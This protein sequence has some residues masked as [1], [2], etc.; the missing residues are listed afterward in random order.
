MR[1]GLKIAR[2]AIA[3]RLVFLTFCLIH[4]PQLF[5]GVQQKVKEKFLCDLCDSS[6][7]GGESIS[8]Q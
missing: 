7:A 1:D 8:K 6:E 2:D 3:R 4:I 5:S